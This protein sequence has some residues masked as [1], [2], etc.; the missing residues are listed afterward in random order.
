MLTG[1]LRSQ[2]DNEDGE[3]EFPYCSSANERLVINIVSTVS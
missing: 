2:V 1:E 3:Q